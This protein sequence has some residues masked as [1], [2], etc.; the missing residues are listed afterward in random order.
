MLLE[1]DGEVIFFKEDTIRTLELRRQ[2]RKVEALPFLIYNWTLNRELNLKNILLLKP[3]ILDNVLSKAIEG[4]LIITNINESKLEM[5]IKTSFIVEELNF[6]G[7][8][9]KEKEHL[10]ECFLI[11]NN[12]FDHRGNL[13]NLP[14]SG[15]LLDQNAKYMYFLSK[16]RKV[17]IEK[18][19]EENN[20]KN[21]AV[22]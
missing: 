1:F 17:L 14:D 20:K 13:V 4:Y 10:K 19:N 16:Y 7:F 15:G 11:K 18:I 22:R 12:L 3:E 6:D 21:K 2:G 9:E 5:F 8:D